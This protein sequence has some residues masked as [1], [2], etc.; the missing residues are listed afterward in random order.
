VRLLGGRLL[1]VRRCGR[2]SVGRSRVRVLIAADENVVVEIAV[3]GIV[4]DVIAVAETRVRV[5]LRT[6]AIR[7]VGIRGWIRCGSGS[8]LVELGRD[9][10]MM[11]LWI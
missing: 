9:L 11:S 5:R 6:D 4:A 10:R 8:L 7:A 3:G 2:V 1:L